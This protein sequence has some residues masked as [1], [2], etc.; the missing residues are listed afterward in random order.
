MY[1]CVHMCFHVRMQ[2]DTFVL[3]VLQ[4]LSQHHRHFGNRIVKDKHAMESTG[5][6][7]GFRRF[8]RKREDRDEF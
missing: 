4:I 6:E 2:I 1:V 5:C 7:G 3:F 8:D